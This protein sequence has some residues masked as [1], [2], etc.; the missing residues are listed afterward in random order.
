MAVALPTPAAAPCPT[1]P[2]A[3]A[4]LPAARGP[5]TA[6]LFDGLGRSAH[7]LKGEPG[8]DGADEDDCQLALYCC[9][10]LH[11]GGFVGVDTDWEWEPSLL[12]FRRRLQA[13]LE[14][15]VAQWVEADVAWA[16]ASSVPGTD[17]VVAGLWAMARERGGP[18][19]SGWLSRH[20]TLAHARELA[21]HRTAYQLKEADPH[22]WG[23]PRLSGAAKAAM[24]AIQVGEYGD[25]DP[26]AV[27]SEL[28]AVTL[29]ALGLDPTPNAYLGR[30][31]ADT[32]RATNL[33]SMFGLNRRWRGALVGHLALFEMTS[34]GPMRRYAETLARLG[35]PPEARRFYEVH[36]AAD[37][38]HELVATREMVPGLLASEPELGRDVLFGAAALQAVEGR[39]AAATIEAWQAGRSSL[40]PPGRLPVS[41]VRRPV[42]APARG[43]TVAL[44]AGP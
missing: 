43:A 30:L 10:E 8:V 17:E 28:F 40:R 7:E 9:Y 31:P 42:A 1:L 22:T 41:A 21:V 38:V 16:G 3:A 13:R 29:A 27:H 44:E 20:G 33:V 11:Y 35:L 32:L 39:A 24:V 36:V 6:W 2:A 26:A 23:I 37:A 19:L 5:L 15:Q 12:A 14:R 34:T 25:G 4:R 18:S